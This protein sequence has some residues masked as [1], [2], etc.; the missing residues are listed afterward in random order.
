M[1]SKAEEEVRVKLIVEFSNQWVEKEAKIQND[2]AQEKAV[3]QKEKMKVKSKMSCG[4]SSRVSKQGPPR[5]L[6]IRLLHTMMMM[7]MKTMLMRWTQPT[8]V[9]TPMSSYVYIICLFGPLCVF[10]DVWT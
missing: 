2:L 6:Q 7:K 8:R 1:S 4:G 5:H 10:Y 3:R 9:M